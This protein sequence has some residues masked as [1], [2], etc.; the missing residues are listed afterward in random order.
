MEFTWP[1]RI[2]VGSAFATG[3]ILIG[4]LS[5]PLG[6]PAEPY[7]AVCFET[8]GLSDALVLAAVAFAAGFT[9]YFLSWPYGR[10]IGI[11]AVPAGLAVW[12]LRGGSMADLLKLH[13]ELEQRETLLAAFKWEPLLWLAIVAFGFLGVVAAAW[14][15]GRRAAEPAKKDGVAKSGMYLNNAIAFAG[16]VLIAQFCIRLLAQDVK[17]HDA[18]LG[19][20]VGQPAAAQI[21]FGV[22]FAFVIC[23]FVVKK[24]LDSSY[25]WPCLASGFVSAF[26]LAIYVNQKVLRYLYQALP[27]VFFSNAC[28]AVLPVQMVSF[29]VLGSVAGYWLAVRYT[30]WRK[31]S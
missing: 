9:A 21:A 20:V 30:Y 14:V 23:G 15:C 22:F 7:A 26:V 2:R 10:Q 5:W 24:T 29:G 31:H 1:I 25:V 17:I 13:P 3:V 16:S 11:L 8:V 28:A 27:P 18:H 6:R 19:L 4:I 12:S